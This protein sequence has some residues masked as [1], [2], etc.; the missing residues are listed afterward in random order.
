MKI[1]LVDD[2]RTERLIMTA[3]LNKLGHEVVLGENGQQAVELYQREMPDLVI[4][5]VVMPVMD[6]HQ[7]AREIR[8]RSQDWVPIIFLSG[9][10][11]PEDIAA[12]IHAGGDDYLAKPVNHTVLEAKMKAMQRIAVMR[13]QLLDVTHELEMANSELKQL[14]NVDGLTGLS[15]RRHMEEALRIEIARCTRNQSPLTIALVDVDHFKAYNDHYGHLEGDDCL[16][17]V[18]EALRSIC[19]RPTDVVARY[20]GEEFALILTDTPPDGAIKMAELA[21]QSVR[22]LKIPHLKSSAA[23]VCTVSV[24]VYSCIPQPGEKADLLLERADSLLYKAKNSGRNHVES[25]MCKLLQ[26]MRS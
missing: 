11:G 22:D 7:A 16:K 2:T 24:G 12:G 9:R 20:G 23:D 5:D 6:G 10:V 4:M 14:V 26:K 13:H 19:K 1:L 21:N 17:K 3:Y 8:A 25:G 15:N 18:A